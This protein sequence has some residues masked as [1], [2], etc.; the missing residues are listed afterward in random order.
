[1]E[2]TYIEHHGTFSP[3][4]PAQSGAFINLTKEHNFFFF[5]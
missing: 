5:N 2:A 3:A 4:I 1:M